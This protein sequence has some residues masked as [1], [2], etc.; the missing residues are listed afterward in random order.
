[1]STNLGWKA[2]A[3]ASEHAGVFLQV[4]LY[5]CQDQERTVASIETRAGV[6]LGSAATLAGLSAVILRLAPPSDPTPPIAVVIT[7]LAAAAFIG[8]FLCFFKVV[9]PRFHQWNSDPNLEYF[10]GSLPAFNGTEGAAQWA[11]RHMAKAYEGN[12]G[13]VDAK[14]KALRNALWFLAAMPVLV[15]FLAIS[16]AV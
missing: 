2:G 8:V 14:A 5:R 6:A 7:A 9:A 12:L 4:A 10:H 16:L 13:I 11:G 3:G 1:M 15:V